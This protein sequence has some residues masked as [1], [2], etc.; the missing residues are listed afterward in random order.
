MHT[1]STDVPG[2][3]EQLRGKV[4]LKHWRLYLKDL[5]TFIWKVPSFS[6]FLRSTFEVQPASM[7]LIWV[8]F[9]HSTCKRA[10][11]MFPVCS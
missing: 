2:K 11:I 4:L 5:F 7:V 9:K 6:V 1:S 3:H 8:A 10:W